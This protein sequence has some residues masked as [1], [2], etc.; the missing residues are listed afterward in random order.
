MA[1][2]DP[3][4]HC[5]IIVLPDD[6]DEASKKHV[7]LFQ[8]MPDKITD[9]KSA[10]FNDA[11]IIGR[12]SPLKTY[13]FSSARRISLNLEFFASLEAKDVNENKPLEGVTKVKET[14][15][16]LRA[17]VNPNYG[18][19]LIA[20]PRKC[21]LRVGDNIGMIGFC[22]SVN[23]TLRGDYPW[24]LNPAMAHY[25]SVALTFE[26]TG[27]DV[28]SFDDIRQGEDLEASISLSRNASGGIVEVAA[29]VDLV[30]SADGQRLINP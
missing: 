21:I 22:I 26:E 9:S 15:K 24:E 12:S 10:V 17:L 8:T 3:S 25:A 27:E 30:R 16:L 1:D 23:V 2:N 11:Q 28:Y 6:G 7:I 18:S 14:V 19:K 5:Y 4:R 29:R 20:R 13:Q